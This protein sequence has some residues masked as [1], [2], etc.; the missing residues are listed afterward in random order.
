MTAMHG[1]WGPGMMGGPGM[2]HGPGMMMGS[3]EMMGWGGM[4]GYYTK[5]TPEQHTA[6]PVHDGPVHGHA[7]DDDGPHDVAS[8]VDGAAASPCR[9]EVA[10]RTVWSSQSSVWESSV[11]MPFTA[12][13]VL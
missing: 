2:K 12:V 9:D 1:M 13:T 7:A 6:A 3:P 5:L 11:K 10:L 8:A 4:R